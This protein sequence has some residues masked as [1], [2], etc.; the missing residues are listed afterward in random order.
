MV[1]YLSTCYIE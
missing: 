1:T